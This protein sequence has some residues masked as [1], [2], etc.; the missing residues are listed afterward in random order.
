MI[1]D[2]IQSVA[3]RYHKMEKMEPGWDHY[4]LKHLWWLFNYYHYGFDQTFDSLFAAKDWEALNNFYYQRNRLDIFPTYVDF[5]FPSW[6]FFNALIAIAVGDDKG[7]EH[8]F[9][10]NMSLKTHIEIRKGIYPLCRVGEILLAGMWHRNAEILDY[11]IPK[12]VKFAAGKSP[13]WETATVA[14]MLALQEHNVSKASEY[15][16][17][18]CKVMHTDF[19]APDKKLYIS[20][21]GLYRL[22]ARILDEDEFQK[23]SM[24]EYKTF[25]REYAEWRNSHLE[26]PKLYMRYPEPVDFINDMLTADWRN[27]EWKGREEFPFVGRIPVEWVNAF[28]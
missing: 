5:D 24:P 17:D 6:H 19:N 10:S 7:V 14:Y 22:A 8:L 12:A 20:A 1:D 11:A 21:H 9:P 16:N 2:F 3:E 23:L 13:K 4:D 15:L 18:A 26:P 27:I 25:C 28:S